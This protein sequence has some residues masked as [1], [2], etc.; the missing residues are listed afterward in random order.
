[1]SCDNQQVSIFVVFHSNIYDELYEQLNDEDK[2]KIVM[3]GVNT[4]YKKNYN[5][6]HVPIFEYDLP[7]YN[8]KFQEVGFDEAS[9]LYHVYK[10]KLYPQ[11]PTKYVGFAQ[12]D[13]KFHKD[14]FSHV[15]NV[16]SS[17]PDREHIFYI[18][19]FDLRVQKIVGALRIYNT[20]PKNAVDNYNQMFGTKF[21]FDDLKRA[22]CVIMNNTFV[23]ST[24]L[25][26]KL[27]SWLQQYLDP[28]LDVSHI[29]SPRYGNLVEAL[30]GMFLAFEMLQGAQPHLLKINHVWPHYKLKSY[31]DRV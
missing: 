31:S 7:E 19:G 3:Y 26:E 6:I 29:D 23:I 1:M 30:V 25:F 18:F 16:I 8:S 4:K 15:E 17:T 2:R 5:P 11:Q 20:P 21:S 9:A 12:Y 13:M 10:N 14:T 27:M 22:P 24:R 28:N